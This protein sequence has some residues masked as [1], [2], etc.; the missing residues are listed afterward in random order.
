MIGKYKA[1]WNIWFNERIAFERKKFTAS[2]F[3]SL[4]P[5]L[6]IAFIM[7][8]VCLGI[9]HGRF[10]IGDLAFYN[11]VA[12]QFFAGTSSLINAFNQSFESE[13]RLTNFNNFL[14]WETRVKNHGQQKIRTIDSIEFKDVC[15]TY[16]KTSGKVLDGVSFSIGRNEKI[17]LVGVNGAGKSTVVKLLLRLYDADSGEVLVNGINIREYDIGSLR[18]AIGVVFQDYN[19]YLLPI[20]EAV[21]ISD[22]NG[23]NDEQRVKEALDNADFNIDGGNFPHGIHT[24]LSKLFTD[25]GVELSGGQWQKL[26]IAQAYFKK[27]AFLIMDEPSAALDPAA[28]HRIF[29][30]MKNLCKDKGAIFITHRLS[31]VSAA[32]R[33]IVINSGRCTEAGT[34]KELMELNGVYAR[35]FTYQAE[36]YTNINEG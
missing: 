13:L 25:D 26:A 1:L 17:A 16:P 29:H 24:S 14:K 20:N 6:P 7:F 21:A 12:T 18:K 36:K 22:I 27:S 15:F 5:F 32:D 3:A 2:F 33:I 9:I 31:C 4:I 11:G 28:E 35:L 10:S 30:K 23:T 19:R 34:H 8:Y